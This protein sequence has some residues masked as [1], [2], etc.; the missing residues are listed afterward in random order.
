MIVRDR[1]NFLTPAVIKLKVNHKTQVNRKINVH[2]TILAVDS[3][4]YGELQ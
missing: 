4:S 3:C 2:M 1:E